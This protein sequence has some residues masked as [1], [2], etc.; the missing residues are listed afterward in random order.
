MNLIMIK[1]TLESQS[2]T[3]ETICV[4]LGCSHPEYI[5]LGWREKHEYLR[6]GSP[7]SLNSTAWFVTSIT[8]KIFQIL[9]LLPWRKWPMGRKNNTN[10]FLMLVSLK[11]KAVFENNIL[12]FSKEPLLCLFTWFVN[13]CFWIMRVGVKEA[14]VFLPLPCK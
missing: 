6:D 4:S 12:G 13:I 7:K 11:K 1:V 5:S 9:G 3:K 14:Q 2:G 10:L 8:G